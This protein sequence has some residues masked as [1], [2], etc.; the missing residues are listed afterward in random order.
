MSNENQAHLDQ[1]TSMLI[2]RLDVVLLPFADAHSQEARKEHLLGLCK[3]AE[4]VGMLLLSQ[5]AEWTFE[6]S[7]S[8]GVS[9]AS[10]GRQA[11]KSINSVVVFPGLVRLT[12][13]TARK[14]ERPRVVLEPRVK[15]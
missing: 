1:A 9:G 12:D 14:L 13:N 4:R 3:R 11:R 5:P 8:P 6:W 2:Q 15:G 10:E 7:Y